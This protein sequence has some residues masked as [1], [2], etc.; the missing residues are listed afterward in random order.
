MFFLG[1]MY[2]SNLIVEPNYKVFE[3]VLG[4]EALRSETGGSLDRQVSP[5]KEY[6]AR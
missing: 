2:F 3:Q 4:P 6:T 5:L 1:D